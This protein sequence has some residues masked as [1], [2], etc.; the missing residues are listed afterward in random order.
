MAE[1]SLNR[2]VPERKG[3]F[4]VTVLAHQATLTEKPEVS[5]ESQTQGGLKTMKRRIM[6]LGVAAAMMILGVAFAVQA[7]P[8]GHGFRGRGEGPFM[9]LKAFLDLKLTDTQQTA[10][11]NVMNKYQDQTENLRND[12]R[13]AGRGVLAVLHAPVF[14]EQEARKAFRAASAVKEELFVLR[15]KMMAEMKG[16]LTPEQLA[17]LKERRA[18]GLER[19]RHGLA[20]FSEVQ[21]E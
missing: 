15:T 21:G 13:E 4:F 10:L 19:L 2:N 17:L 20:G 11:T 18:Q 8:F 5:G 14:D 16:L 3:S 9:A 12:L 7:G 6:L 1:H